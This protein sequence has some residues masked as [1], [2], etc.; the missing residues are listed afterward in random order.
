MGGDFAENHLRILNQHRQS[1][2]APSVTWTTSAFTRVRNVN[3][4]VVF[5][6]QIFAVGAEKIVVVVIE[7]DI[8]MAAAV[9]V[10][11]ILISVTDQEGLL[12]ANTGGELKLQ[13][14]PIPKI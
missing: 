6:N 13:R 9:H 2:Q 14:L 5:A 10:G 7:R 11:M 12:W 1:K 3:G 8:H 4:A